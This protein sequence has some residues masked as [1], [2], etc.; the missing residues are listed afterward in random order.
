MAC[1]VLS[2]EQDQIVVNSDYPHA[3]AAFLNHIT[4]RFR[5]FGSTIPEADT[6]EKELWLAI[7]AHG[8]GML[9]ARV[10]SDAILQFGVCPAWQPEAELRGPILR[11]ERMLCCDG[12]FMIY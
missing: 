2:S 8:E 10:L 1:F 6:W 11:N 7:R 3:Y 9:P 5:G 12:D 4:G